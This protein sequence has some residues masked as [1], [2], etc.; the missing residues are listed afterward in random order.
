M[1]TDIKTILNANWDTTIIAKGTIEYEELLPP[2]FINDGV[3]IVDETAN[4]APAG[5]TRQQTDAFGGDIFRIKLYGTTADNVRLRISALIKIAD[6]FTGNARYTRLYPQQQEIVWDKGSE[7]RPLYQYRR[8]A[9]LPVLCSKNN[10]S[11]Y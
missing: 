11:L 7:D 9:Q 2:E 5:F 8:M 10:V 3:G 6:T 4:Y 1:S